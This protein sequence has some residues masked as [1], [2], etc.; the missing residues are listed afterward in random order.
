VRPLR[1]GKWLLL[2]SRTGQLQDT[3]PQ[4]VHLQ[5]SIDQVC[6]LQEHVRHV[7]FAGF[8]W[9]HD[10]A[11]HRGVTTRLLDGWSSPPGIEHVVFL[12]STRF[13][14]LSC[15]R[16]Q[17]PLPPS[18]LTSAQDVNGAFMQTSSNKQD[19]ISSS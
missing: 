2:S 18:H 17:L 11:T 13:F 3:G 14:R 6:E 15:N 5:F 10:E 19:A 8:M 16:G 7:A 1:L 9:I 4:A 12:K